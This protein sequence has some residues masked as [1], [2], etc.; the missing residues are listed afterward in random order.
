MQRGCTAYDT[1]E[2]VGWLALKKLKGTSDCVVELQWQGKQ[3]ID[4]LFVL[5]ICFRIHNDR[6]TK[7]YTL[8]LYNCHFVSWTIVMI[9]VR[10]TVRW[11]AGSDA[12]LEYGI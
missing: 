9:V 7:R 10:N 8:Q 2:E 6:W 1:I 3:T 4:L 5:S 11:A 12:A